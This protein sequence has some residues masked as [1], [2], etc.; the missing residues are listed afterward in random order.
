MHVIVGGVRVDVEGGGVEDGG[1]LEVK[2]EEAKG[3][4]VNA[5]GVGVGRVIVNGD[6]AIARSAASLESNMAMRGRSL[7]VSLRMSYYISI[8]NSIPIFVWESV[9]WRL[10]YL[11]VAEADYLAE[12]L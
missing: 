4:G 10:A 12:P 6:A 5:G 2:E 7:S 9:S 8:V 1:R 3:F 11:Q